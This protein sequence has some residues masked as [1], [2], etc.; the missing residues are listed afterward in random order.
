MRQSHKTVLLWITLI[1]AFVVIWQFLNG[2]RAQEN[3][4]LFSQ[5]VQEVDQHPERFKPGSAITIL[6]RSTVLLPTISSDVSTF[7][8]PVPLW[9]KTLPWHGQ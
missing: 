1:F 3:H 5:F 2:Q 8:V 6:W 7:L 9:S 4:V